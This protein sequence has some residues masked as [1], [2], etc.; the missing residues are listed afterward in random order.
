MLKIVFL[1]LGNFTGLPN[2]IPKAPLPLEYSVLRWGSNFS[3]SSSYVLSINNKLHITYIKLYKIKDDLSYKLS[4]VPILEKRTMIGYDCQYVRVVKEADSK[5]AG[6]S[7]AGS[8]PAADV[9]I[10][11]YLSNFKVDF[12]LF[13]F[14]EI[15]RNY[16]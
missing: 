1:R 3:L 5:S 10:S 14:I 8:N 6:F 11:L 4:D 12:L 13:Y 15:F 9:F 7:R 2:S 16:Y